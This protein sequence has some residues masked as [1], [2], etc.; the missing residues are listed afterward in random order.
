MELYV[1]IWKMTHTYLIL[2]KQLDFIDGKQ[3]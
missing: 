2:E 3:R 1:Q